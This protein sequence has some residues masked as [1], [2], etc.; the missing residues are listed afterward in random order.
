MRINIVYANPGGKNTFCHSQQCLSQLL[1]QFKHGCDGW[2]DFNLGARQFVETHCK[3]HAL[4][5]YLAFTFKAFE[6]PLCLAY[7]IKL[8]AGKSFLKVLK[9]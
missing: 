3:I 6:R 9:R 2:F 5:V 8:S 7:V 1:S 4:N